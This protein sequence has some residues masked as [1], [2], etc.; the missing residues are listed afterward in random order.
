MFAYILK[1]LPDPYKNYQS[2]MWFYSVMGKGN[3]IMYQDK[4]SYTNYSLYSQCEFNINTTYANMCNNN[5]CV[6]KEDMTE[7]VKT[8]GNIETCQYK[9][10]S[11]ISMYVV[12]FGYYKNRTNCIYTQ[13]NPLYIKYECLC[14]NTYQITFFS[15]DQKCLFRTSIFENDTFFDDDGKIDCSINE[16][17]DNDD[18][19]SFN[20]LLQ[21]DYQC[22]NQCINKSILPTT[23]TTNQI[24]SVNKMIVNIGL[25]IIIIIMVFWLI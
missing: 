24:S 5:D 25:I 18:V 8:D 3:G 16:C 14:D 19:D 22:S 2:S 11:S 6:S 17:G 12:G 20:F 21:K 9:L 23:T 1:C 10:N 4:E 7:Y 15:S 13:N